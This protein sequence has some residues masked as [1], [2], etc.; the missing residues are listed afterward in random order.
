MD[1][2]LKSKFKIKD[3]IA[4]NHFSLTYMGTTLSGERPVVVKIYKRGTLNSVLIKS[5]KQK[6]K[7]MEE[8]NHPG[9]ATLFDG[10][11]G[12][13]GFY[14]VREYIEGRS[15]DEHLRVRKPEPDEALEIV[16]ET[17]L[18]LDFAHKRGIIHGGLKP[19]NIF[20]NDQRKVK[21]TDFI[22]EGEIKESMP[23][24][25]LYILEGADYASP[26]EIFGSPARAPS[27]IY[28]LGTLLCELLTGHPP[29]RGNPQA[30]LAGL[31]PALPVVPKYVED[32]LA[33]SLNKDP[34][35][36]FSSVEEML[37]SIKCRTLIEIRK[38]WDLP[39]VELENAPR[40]EEKAVT[41]VHKEQKR[42]FFVAIIVLIAVLAGI[43][44]SIIS[45]LIALRQ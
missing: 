9:I 29:F 43:I 18:T 34:L 20:L 14:Y 36:R 42:S 41:V 45:Q 6:V 16:Y 24:K 12:W 4:E 32:I 44:Y 39:A 1:R 28:A 22:I 8:I 21:L 38:T 27:D 26:E 3:K 11:Y 19:T 31:F 33:K 25:A 30:K 37:E 10:D 17:A 5:M 13:Q 7:A 40:A 15:L 23:Q 2:L 35:L